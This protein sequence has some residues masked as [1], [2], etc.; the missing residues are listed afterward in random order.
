PKE[1]IPR[2]AKIAFVVAVSLVF[3]LAAGFLHE[4]IDTTVHDAEEVEA[5]LG[6]GPLAVLP[7]RRR[8]DRFVRGDRPDAPAAESARRLLARLRFAA[9]E[10]PFRSLLLC[11]AVPGDGASTVAANLAAVAA[12]SEGRVLLL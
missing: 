2:W 5:L 8:S 7:R 11:G 3:G 10:K 6:A 1:A 12:R 9:R 4:W